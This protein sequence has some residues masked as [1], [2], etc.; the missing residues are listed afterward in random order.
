[1][2]ELYAANKICQ[3]IE[4]LDAEILTVEKLLNKTLN[5]EVTIKLEALV[6]EITNTK[7]EKETSEDYGSH[8]MFMEML[9]VR[10]SSKTEDSNKNNSK[11]K[12]S[13]STLEFVTMFSALL[14][15]KLEKRNALIEEFN[16]LSIKLKI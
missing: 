5:E 2:K 3:E 6:E 11:F 9:R 7:V 4:K 8:I 14:K 12:S 10:Y 1:M 15:V 13:V 16:Q